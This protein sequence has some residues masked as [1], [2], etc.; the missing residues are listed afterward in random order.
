MRHR[1]KKK[2]STTAV[3]FN[4]VTIPATFIEDKQQITLFSVNF[5]VQN[6]V[7]RK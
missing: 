7:V 6:E 3:K 5:H 1:K 2:N 4:L